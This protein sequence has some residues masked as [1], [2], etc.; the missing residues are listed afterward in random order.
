[1]SIINILMGPIIGSVIGYCTNYIAVKMLFRPLNPVKIGRYTL[2]FTPG[3]IPKRKDKLA[4]ALGNAVGNNLL[5]TSDIEKLFLS[6]EMKN[7]IIDEILDNTERYLNLSIEDLLKQFISEQQFVNKRE[8]ANFFI[9]NKIKDGISNLDFG[10]IILDVGKS[11]IKEKFQGTMIAMFL[12]DDLIQSLAE[13]IGKQAKL[14]LIEHGEKIFY[15]IVEKEINSIMNNK[16]NNLLENIGINK[17]KLRE[18]FVNLYE[19]FIKQNIQKVLLEFDINNIVKEKVNQMEVIELE[20]LV[21]SVMKKE[22]NSI[23]NLG[24]IIGFIIGILN[25]F[26]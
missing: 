14:Y 5:T 18:T 26:V 16:A 22:L 12:T 3:I 24:A 13:P 6:E 23:I 20:N 7:K 9:C 2:P 15:P 17:N 21:L 19:S 25:I 1:M 8:Q 10:Q 4:N 11:A